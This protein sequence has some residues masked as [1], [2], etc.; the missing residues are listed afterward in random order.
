M[1]AFGVSAMGDFITLGTLEQGQVWD[2]AQGVFVYSSGDN[3]MLCMLYGVIT[4]ALTVIILA[5]AYMSMK[6]AYCTQ[7]R[8][9]RGM[10]LPTFRDDL[11]SLLEENI[12]G[13]LMALSL[14]HI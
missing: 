12:H 14:I 9:E 7:A 8:K 11:R 1:A 4:I 10:P 5:V 2:E 13:L 6:S 3:S